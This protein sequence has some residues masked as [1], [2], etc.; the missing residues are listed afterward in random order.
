MHEGTWVHA[1]LCSLTALRLEKAKGGDREDGAMA[2]DY[3][4][5]SK[6]PNHMEANYA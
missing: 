1:S 3:P 6:G 2:M 5:V 4:V